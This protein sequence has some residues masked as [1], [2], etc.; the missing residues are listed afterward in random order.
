MDLLVAIEDTSDTKY[1]HWM[2]SVGNGA[3]GAAL[4]TRFSHYRSVAPDI[5]RDPA[6]QVMLMR[7]LVVDDDPAIH[8]IGWIV[9]A[10]DHDPA[11]HMIVEAVLTVDAGFEIAH[12]NN[13]HEALSTVAELM[14]DVVLLDHVMPDLNGLEVLQKL[15]A[16]PATAEIPV[17]FL[18]GKSDPEVLRS[19]LDQGA[20]AVITKPFHPAELRG[21]IETMLARP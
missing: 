14:P 4:R 7:L 19:L 13:G 21:Q 18:T 10:G 6:P 12:A 17:I 11:I 2:N 8:I 15:R 3:T 1:R 5:K 9:T 20:R 16:E